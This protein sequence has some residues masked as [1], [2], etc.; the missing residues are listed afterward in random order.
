MQ[1][2]SDFGGD[3]KEVRGEMS[4]FVGKQNM[5][6]EWAKIQKLLILR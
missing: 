4:I 1:I 6:K 3:G 2:E 5:V